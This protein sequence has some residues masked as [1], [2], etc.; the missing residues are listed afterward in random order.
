MPLRVELSADQEFAVAVATGLA[1][2]PIQRDDTRT[3]EGALGELLNIVAGNA[4]AVLEAE[5]IHLSIAPP[6]PGG[7]SD[8]SAAFELAM[9]HGKGWLVLDTQP[10]VDVDGAELELD[11]D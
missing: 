2:G 4:V 1:S 9:L 3:L 6:E 5:G 7:R 8:A 11:G 10:S